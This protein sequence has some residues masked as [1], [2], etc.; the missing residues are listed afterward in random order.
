MDEPELSLKSTFV[1]QDASEL[2]K[3]ESCDVAPARGY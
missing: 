3:L 2:L 1:V